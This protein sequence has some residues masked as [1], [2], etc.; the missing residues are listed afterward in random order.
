MRAWDLLVAEPMAVKIHLLSVLPAFLLGTWLLFASQKGSR[1]HRI[2][3]AIYL[4]LMSITAV[5][6]LSVRSIDPPHLSVIHLFVPLTLGSVV[7]ALWAVRRRNIRLHRNAMIGLYVGGL[8]I[9][10]TFTFAPGRLLYR[11][12]FG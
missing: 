5:A 3:G 4:L 1:P 7:A 2:A 8:L 6:T 9:A 10:G 12:A 11:M